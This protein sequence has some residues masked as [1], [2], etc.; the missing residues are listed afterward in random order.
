VKFRLDEK[1][2]YNTDGSVKRWVWIERIDREGQATEDYRRI[3]LH[4]MLTTIDCIKNI[5]GDL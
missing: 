3:D 4:K 1:S 5:V 2:I